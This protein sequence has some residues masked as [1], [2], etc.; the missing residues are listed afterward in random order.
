MKHNIAELI[1]LPALQNVM[2][3][4]FRATGI[5][6]ALLDLQGR[7]L[8]GAGWEDACTEFHRVYPESC[9]NCQISD[10]Y[11]FN[12]LGCATY[13]GYECLNGLFEYATP[14]N[15]NGAHMATIFTGQILHA[16]PDLARFRAQAAQF[17]FDEASYLE[18]IE[19]IAVIPRER[20]PAVMEFLVELAQ[21]LG[22][23]GAMRQECALRIE[24]DKRRVAREM[25]DELGQ[26]LTAQA[27]HVAWLDLRFGND[28]P[29]LRAK[30]GEMAVLL[31]KTIH[32][33]RHLATSVRPAALDLG[34]LAALEWLAA[35]FSQRS[36][37]LC[38]V[39]APSGDIALDDATATG[40]FRIVQEALT[41]IARHANANTVL[42]SLSQQG[43]SLRLS[44]RD[45]GCGFDV[46][47]KRDG[48]GFGLQSMRERAVGLGSVLR[49]ESHSGSGTCIKVE[50]ERAETAGSTSQA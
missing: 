13:V 11:I 32:A 17:G 7:V 3:A 4:L 28:N 44:V 35:D 24:Q 22:R 38:S 29:E 6:H 1:D 8:T 21:M 26:L 23:A 37:I 36:S 27:M 2:D 50:L 15:I 42:I 16:K 30:T 5:N 39:D 47:A 45:D 34:L 31:E 12:H 14:V 25:H 46:A 10:Q 41:N 49:I 40:L 48:A 18:S 33:V 19:K 43:V 20:M 9:K